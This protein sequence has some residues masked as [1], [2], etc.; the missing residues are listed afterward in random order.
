MKSLYQDTFSKGQPQERRYRP[1]TAINEALS[2]KRIGAM[3]S[4][5]KLQRNYNYS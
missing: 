3:H 2:M 1:Q 4:A 5:K